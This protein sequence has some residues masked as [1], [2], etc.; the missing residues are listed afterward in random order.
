MVS[1]AKA[2]TRLA[3]GLALP[4]WGSEVAAAAALFGANAALRV[5]VLQHIP[6]HM[7][8]GFSSIVAGLWAKHPLGLL[9]PMPI[10]TAGVRVYWTTTG[11]VLVDGLRR[12][13]TLEGTY[14]LASGLL[15]IASYSGARLLGAARLLALTYAGLFLFG[16]QLS[17]TFIHPHVGTFYFYYCYL[18]ANLLALSKLLLGDPRRLWRWVFGISLA[19]LMLFLEIWLNYALFALA[20]LPL[21]A[22]WG[23]RQRQPML[24]SRAIR[25]WGVFIVAVLVYVAIRA[26]YPNNLAMPGSEEEII[27]RYPYA[28]LAITDLFSNIVTYLYICFSTY[29][30]AWFLGSVPLMQLG[31]QAIKEQQNGYAPQ[32]LDFVVFHHIFLWYYYAGMAFALFALAGISASRRAFAGGSG[33]ALIV[34]GL[35]LL[36]LAGCA[37]LSLIKYRFYISLPVLAYKCVTGTFATALLVGFGLKWLHDQRSSGLYYA[38]IAATWLINLAAFVTHGREEVQLLKILGLVSPSTRPFI[39][40]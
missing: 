39:G 1:P 16:S 26:Q 36:M 35:L 7:V 19:A 25:L 20:F 4:R 14:I 29:L 32:F 10:E 40:W 38:A 6:N 3:R 37:S 15:L 18:T 27:T 17:Y 8:G 31:A 5:L 2:R 24:A 30:P 21:A 22:F 12:L 9:L 28:S 13:I 11:L 33:A 34:V 23:F